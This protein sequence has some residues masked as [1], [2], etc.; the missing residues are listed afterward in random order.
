MHSNAPALA[1]IK[2]YNVV[3]HAAEEGGYWAEC[4][5]LEGCFTQG[6]TVRQTERNMYEA[7][8]LFLE[9]ETEI[10]FNLLFALKNA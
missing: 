5:Q 4:P 8:E 3:I 6:E 10:D 1:D 2:Q 7:V 9:D